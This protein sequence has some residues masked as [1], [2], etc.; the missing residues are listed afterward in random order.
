MDLLLV[1][2]LEIDLEMDRL[3]EVLNLVRASE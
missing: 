2:R 3:K 1:D